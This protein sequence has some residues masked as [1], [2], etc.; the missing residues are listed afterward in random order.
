MDAGCKSQIHQSIN[1]VLLLLSSAAISFPIGYDKWMMQSYSSQNW[2]VLS[3]KT[4]KLLSWLLKIQFAF[5]FESWPLNPSVKVRLFLSWT[6]YIQVLICSVYHP[7]SAIRLVKVTVEGRTVEIGRLGKYIC[8]TMVLLRTQSWCYPLGL[9]VVLAE[10]WTEEDKEAHTEH[11]KTSSVSY[12][13]MH[14]CFFFSTCWHVD[15]KILHIFLSLGAFTCWQ[16]QSTHH[17]TIHLKNIIQAG[18]HMPI[19][20]RPVLQTVYSLYTL[21]WALIIVVSHVYFV[22]CLLK[23]AMRH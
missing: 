23:L 2:V 9:I 13:R 4:F 5:I 16:A 3:A 11:I 19:N 17:E 7:E 18:V 21:V 6:W 8:Q 1:L 12:L 10:D 22:I 15:K 14:M 20:W